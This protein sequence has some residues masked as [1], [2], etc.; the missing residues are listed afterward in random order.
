M[1]EE[2]QP[3]ASI[4][5]IKTYVGGKWKKFGEYNFREM[6]LAASELIDAY[7]NANNIKIS[8]PPQNIIKIVNKE[9]VQAMMVDFTKS[10]EQT[11]DYNYSLNKD[12]FNT[13]LC[14]LDFLSDSSTSF[15]K[16]IEARLI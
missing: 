7:C 3:Y 16:K 2:K 8:D 4:E 5:D 10:S 11:G 13:V 14:K 1:P 12:A 9:L 6:A 15:V